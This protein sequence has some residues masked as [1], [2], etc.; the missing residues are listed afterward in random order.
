MAK[1]ITPAKRNIWFR[2]GHAILMYAIFTATE[3]FMSGLFNRP[4]DESGVL[5]CLIFYLMIW[6]ER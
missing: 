4:F 6:T 5:T 1:K 2:A 3:A